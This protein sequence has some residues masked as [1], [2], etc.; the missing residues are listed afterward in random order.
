[1][2]L[3][4]VAALALALSFEDCAGIF[5]SL[6]SGLL[7]SKTFGVLG[8]FSSSNLAFLESVQGVEVL[9]LFKFKLWLSSG[10]LRYLS[11]F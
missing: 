7:K 6:L 2:V 1:M 4:P 10:K 9:F 8:L 5:D 3:L 11:N